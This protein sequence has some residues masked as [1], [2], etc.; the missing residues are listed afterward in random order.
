LKPDQAKFFG[1]QKWPDAFASGHFITLYFFFA[2]L[3]K[4]RLTAPESV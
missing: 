1:L 2:A 3:P 4:R